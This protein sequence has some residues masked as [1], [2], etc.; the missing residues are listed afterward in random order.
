MRSAKLEHTVN[1]RATQASMRIIELENRC[2]VI[3][4]AGSN[5][6]LSAKL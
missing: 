1:Y 4:T 6:A 5:L 3:R 2:A